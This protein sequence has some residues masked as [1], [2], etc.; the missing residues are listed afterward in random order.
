MTL[1]DFQYADHTVDA[2]GPGL[3][4]APYTPPIDQTP[5][6]YLGFDGALPADL[7]GL[8]FAPPEPNEEP[9]PVAVKWEGFDG[10]TWTVLTVQDETSGLVAPGIVSAVWPGTSAPVSA[11]VSQGKDLQAT[12]TDPRQVAAFKPGQRFY[13]AQNGAGETVTLDSVV[14]DTLTFTTPLSR[15]YSNATIQLAVMPRF[16]TPRSWIRARLQ[17]PVEPPHTL[18]NGLYV[19]AVWASQMQTYQNET[20]GGSAGE[21]DQTYF[22]RQTPVLEDEI[23]EIRELDNA[24][25]AVELPMLRDDLARRGMSDADLRIVTNPRSGEITEVWVRWRVNANLLFSGP[26]DRECHAG[27]HRRPPDFGR[28]NP[29]TH[30]TGGRRQRAG[31]RVPLRRRRSSAT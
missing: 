30:T 22:F 11:T 26:D 27:A 25:A 8:Y 12:V 14:R 2:A 20:L 21:P 19:N 10:D 13:I 3:A 29:W 16:G 1:N 28:R 23:I 9:T 6:L 18:V 5:T 4:F 31:R 17:Q 15:D 7:I 24:R